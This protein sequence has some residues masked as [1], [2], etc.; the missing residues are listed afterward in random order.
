MKC[1][2]FWLVYDKEAVMP[3]EFVV[4][5]LCVSLVIQMTDEHSLQ[6][7][8]DELMELEEDHMMQD[9]IRWLKSRDKRYGMIVTF[10]RK[11]SGMDP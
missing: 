1:I 10:A 2:P 7:M 4:P 6:H 5:S 8:L 11:S 9:S 3:P